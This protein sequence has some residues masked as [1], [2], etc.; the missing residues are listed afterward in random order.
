MMLYI[1]NIY[2]LEFLE[3]NMYADGIHIV[4]TGSATNA[5]SNALLRHTRKRCNVRSYNT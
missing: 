4:H 5:V 2:A 3:I 1:I